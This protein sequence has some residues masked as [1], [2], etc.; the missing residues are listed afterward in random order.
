MSE[1]SIDF[2]DPPE[3]TDGKG[4]SKPLMMFW[5]DGW[6]QGYARNALLHFLSEEGLDDRF[7]QWIASKEKPSS[8]PGLGLPPEIATTATTDT[9]QMHCKRCNPDGRGDQPHTIIDRDDGIEKT[10]CMTCNYETWR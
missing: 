1:Y 2:S 10:R 3:P 8:F 6:D 5:G 9:C 4:H 7:M